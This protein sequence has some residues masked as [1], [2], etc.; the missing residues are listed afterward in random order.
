MTDWLRELSIASRDGAVGRVA[1]RFALVAA[2]GELATLWGILP[3]REGEAALAARRC[4]EDWHASRKGTDAA[5]VRHAINELR[6]F[7]RQSGESEF[8][9][10]GDLESSTDYTGYRRC[11]EDGTYYYF[12]REAFQSLVGQTAVP[13]CHYLADRG[14]TQIG[15]DGK[16][17]HKNAR[18]YVVTPRLFKE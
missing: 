13:I 5:E 1:I 11:G 16:P 6:T 12:H 4:F 17:G 8:L 7:I 15:N 10:W 18:Y 9:N 14:I 2:A 3:W